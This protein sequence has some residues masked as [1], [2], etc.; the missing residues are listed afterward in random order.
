MLSPGLILPGQRIEQGG[1]TFQF[2]ED[3][4]WA[5]RINYC[6]DEIGNDPLRMNHAH[7]MQTD[8][9][10]IATDINEDNMGPAEFHA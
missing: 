7:S 8:E 4:G 6:L 3:Q 5:S 9:L 10:G 1:V 2:V